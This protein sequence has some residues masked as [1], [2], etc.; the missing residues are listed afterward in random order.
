M[1]HA[2]ARALKA[3]DRYKMRPEQFDQVIIAAINVTLC[4]ASGGDSRVAEGFNNDIAGNGRGFRLRPG[5]ERGLVG[6]RDA[7]PRENVAVARVNARAIA[8][9]CSSLSQNSPAMISVSP[10]FSSLNHGKP[11]TSIV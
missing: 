10:E 6:P 3:I 5:N 1:G 4:L 8:P 2:V 9:H 11:K 7:V